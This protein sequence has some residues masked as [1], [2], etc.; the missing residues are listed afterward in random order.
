MATI[1]LMLLHAFQKNGLDGVNLTVR[2]PYYPEFNVGLDYSPRSVK[3]VLQ[4]LNHLM[5]M[6]MNFNELDKEI[7]EIEG[8]LDSIRK[9]NAEFNTYLEELEKTYTETP[10]EEP[11]DISPDEALKFAEELLKD[12][13]DRKKDQ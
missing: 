12:N 7:S 5:T 13:R 11:F 9:K 10:Y 2:V 6:E 1:N 4:R 8:K 3:A